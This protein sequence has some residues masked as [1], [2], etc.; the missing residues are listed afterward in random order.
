MSVYKPFTSQDYAVVPFNAHKQY[1]LNSSSAALQQIKFFNAKYT[2][3]SVDTYISTNGLS[4]VDNIK[5]QQIDH[6][7]YRN[8]HLMP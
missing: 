5:Y 6:L 1:T 7:F 2:S 8:Y 3:G 4:G